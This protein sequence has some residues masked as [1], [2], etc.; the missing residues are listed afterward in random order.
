MAKALYRGY[1]FIG[2]LKSVEENRLA[3]SAG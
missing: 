1:A 2:K 3:N